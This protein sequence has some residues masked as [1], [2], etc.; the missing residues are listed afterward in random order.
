PRQEGRR[1]MRAAALLGLAALVGCAH[2]SGEAR[3][4]Q[5]EAALSQRPQVA[6][7]APFAAP[8]PKEHKLANGLRVL[9]VEKPSD[10]IEALQLVVKKGAASDPQGLPGLASLAME[11]L[12]AGS[13]KRTQAEMAR[14]ADAIGATIRAGSGV[15]GSIVTASAM[16]TQL[17]K[18]V[19]L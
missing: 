4:A 3:N 5:G 1:A 10:G 16:A 15:D 14:A 11:M 9:I 12:E 8:V 19:P 7:L 17:E 13:A 2:A 18:L 6:P